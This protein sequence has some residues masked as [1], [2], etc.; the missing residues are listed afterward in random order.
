MRKRSQITSPVLVHKFSKTTI[1]QGYG[2]QDCKFICKEFVDNF[3]E[4]N[5]AKKI[6]LRLTNYPL[7]EAL[8][9]S[10]GYEY[11]VVS[12]LRWG[13]VE[14]GIGDKLPLWCKKGPMY[15]PFRKWLRTHPDLRDFQ[16]DI[17]KE[18]WISVFTID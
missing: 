17:R 15:F 14:K 13:L 12:Y 10:F 4:I 3:F 8:H 9:I 11:E 5:N 2:Y 16:K 18:M 1:Y 7:K 6:Q